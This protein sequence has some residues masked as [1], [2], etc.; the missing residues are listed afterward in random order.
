MPYL[1][2]S[3][4]FQSQHTAAKD[5]NLSGKLFRDFALPCLAP[6][7]L[8]TPTRRQPILR[9]LYA[10]APTTPAGHLQVRT[11]CGLCMVSLL[12]TYFSIPS[13]CYLVCCGSQNVFVIMSSLYCAG[14]PNAS[15]GLEQHACLLSLPQHS[16]LPRGRLQCPL[17]PSFFPCFR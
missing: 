6:V 5:P 10:F 16:R 9:L 7:L 3:A 11:F 12:P 1:S 4:L 15:A 13:A 17:H 14:Y 8:S 2:Y